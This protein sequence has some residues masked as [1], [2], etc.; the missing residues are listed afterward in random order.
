MGFMKKMKAAMGAGAA[1]VETELSSPACYPGGMV[2][3]TVA[4]KGGEVEQKINFLAVH[5]QAE[6]E[7]EGED[8]E[9]KQNVIFHTE[10]LSDEFTIGP[11]QANSFPFQMG[12]PWETPL[13]NIGGSHLRGMKVG[14]KTELDIAG[15]RDAFDFDEIEVLP[16]PAHERI[17]A[18]LINLGFTFKSSDVEKGKAPG[19]QMPFY[20]EIEFAPGGQYSGR[21]NELE[22]TF[23]T[24]PQA[25]DVLLEI[26]TRGGFFTE[27]SDNVTRFTVP[28]MGFEQT[29]WENVLHD[30]ITAAGSRRGLW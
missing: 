16:L 12:I 17:L 26:D 19:S 5:L 21:I 8:S 24:T 29:P 1:E 3:G 27:G 22:L 11:G 25:V 13:T 18:G 7:V 2:G 20:Q 23:L 28:L 14:V 9:W 4:F 6:V 15:G 10:R 30:H